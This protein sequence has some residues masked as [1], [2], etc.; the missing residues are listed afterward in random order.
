[1]HI[2]RALFDAPRRVSQTGT[3]AGTTAPD[4]ND[5]WAFTDPNA[6]DLYEREGKLRE[7][8]HDIRYEVMR[9]GPWQ[10]EELEYK[11]EIGRLLQE[12]AV[13]N[14]GTFW[15]TSPF[16]TVYRAVRHGSL[17]VA[18]REYRFRPGDDIV[19]QCRMMRDMRPGLAGPLLI[20]R[21]RPAHEA[22]LCGQ[23]AEAMKG[24]GGKT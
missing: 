18:D 14:K 22:R 21:L 8:E 1:M 17:T 2:L 15:F 6:R 24:T 13:V 20:A 10:P 19:F 16:P 9:G 3:S 12:G 11:R 5:V 4:P 7:L 23:M